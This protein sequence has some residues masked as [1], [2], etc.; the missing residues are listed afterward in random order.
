MKVIST[1]NITPPSSFS[2]EEMNAKTNKINLSKSYES[3]QSSV[4]T[5]YR[6]EEYQQRGQDATADVNERD[7][8]SPTNTLLSW[9]DLP[10]QSAER[11]GL[12]DLPLDTTDVVEVEEDNDATTT[13]VA[14]C[15]LFDTSNR[16]D[17]DTNAD[18]DKGT[19]IS[20]V[21]EEEEEVVEEE[22]V[23]EVEQGG[24]G[25]FESNFDDT[26]SKGS[27]KSSVISEVVEDIKQ[28]MAGK[29]DND[30][31]TV[32]TAEESMDDDNLYS[33]NIDKVVSM[34]EDDGQD[35]VEEDDGQDTIESVP[36]E[37]TGS[38]TTEV[39]TL[40]TDETSTLQSKYT[41]DTIDTE[42]TEVAAESSHAKS[43]SWFGGLFSGIISS[44]TAAVEEEEATK[45]A[46]KSVQDE[47]GSVVK[48]LA[49]KAD[50]T[51][52]MVLKPVENIIFPPTLEEQEEL[53]KLE[54]EKK[55]LSTEEVAAESSHVKS[56]SWFG[57]FF[58]SIVSSDE[59]AAAAVKEPIKD[60][61][62]VV[63]DMTTRVQEASAV[64]TE[65]L[66]PVEDAIF[67]QA[68]T[69]EEKLAQEEDPLLNLA[70]NVEEIVAETVTVSKLP[71]QKKRW[72]VR[73]STKKIRSM[74]AKKKV[75][76]AKDE[77][78][79]YSM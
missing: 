56:S 70:S 72:K 28:F 45:K 47:E 8:N 10:D 63:K 51:I 33:T 27:E 50:E 22:D 36:T 41:M 15:G 49:L 38:T 18:G 44:D 76:Q 25:L 68:V 35:T 54:E 61:G 65:A 20:E 43:S 39:E 31:T 13:H 53:A 26:G 34:D 62:S 66:K 5:E 59:P 60:E 30:S 29:S 9:N 32:G 4:T 67:P 12:N 64:V 57:G 6:N 21:V 3:N 46:D 24:C 37:E 17:D 14:T 40:E 52:G 71:E 77:G 73:I 42:A 2:Y 23:E 11:K 19:V 1:V 78:I 69:E 48:D 7:T 16:F 74:F 55:Q 58:S 79:L 75:A